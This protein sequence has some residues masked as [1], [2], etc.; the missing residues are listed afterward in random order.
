MSPTMPSFEK[1]QKEV[2]V[3]GH[4]GLNMHILNVVLGKLIILANLM[5]SYFSRWLVTYIMP[6]QQL[7]LHGDP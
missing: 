7:V 4:N 6:V 1:R 2:S 3:E 5:V